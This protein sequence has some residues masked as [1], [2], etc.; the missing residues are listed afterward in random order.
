[1]RKND[2]VTLN[3]MTKRI[4]SANGK[5]KAVIEPTSIYAPDSSK[6]TTLIYDEDKAQKDS[7]AML[8]VLI[9]DY[10]STGGDGFDDYFT[11]SNTKQFPYTTYAYPDGTQMNLRN[12]VTEF[13]KGSTGSSCPLSYLSKQQTSN[14]TLN[15]VKLN[16]IKRIY[17]N[18][19]I[20]SLD[21]SSP[22]IDQSNA[23]CVATQRVLARSLDMLDDC[24]YEETPAN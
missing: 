5:I 21:D 10:M 9:S 6:S 20:E 1:M 18:G 4:N 16:L 23:S 14:D 8:K 7:K 22:L 24:F 13:F 2:F 12:M 11:K 3:K 17:S 19:N 15:L